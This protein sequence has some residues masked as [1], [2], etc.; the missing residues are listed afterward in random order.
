MM[1]VASFEAMFRT[2]FKQRIQ[3]QK[4]GQLTRRNAEIGGNTSGMATGR[5]FNWIGCS[6]GSGR[7]GS[8]DTAGQLESQGPR[9]NSVDW[10]FA[11]EVRV[12]KE[13]LGPGGPVPSL[14][15]RQSGVRRPSGISSANFIGA[16]LAGF[17]A[18]APLSPLRIKNPPMNSQQSASPTPPIVPPRPNSLAYRLVRLVV[19]S[20]A[21]AASASRPCCRTCGP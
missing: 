14:G 21:C 10:L 7:K 4:K 20:E 12:G 17:S 2:D 16:K 6:V 1:L 18:L 13:R 11:R 5:G 3:G 8:S 9:R 19:D 15:D